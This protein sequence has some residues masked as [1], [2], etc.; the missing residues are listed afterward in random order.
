MFLNFAMYL[1]I[2]SYPEVILNQIAVLVKIEK[3]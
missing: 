2:T 3:H 1:T